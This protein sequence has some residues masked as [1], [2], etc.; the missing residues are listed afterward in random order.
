M[1]IKEGFKE[2]NEV[3]DFIKW[4]SENQHEEAIHRRSDVT[5]RLWTNIRIKENLLLK[6]SRLKWDNEG[7]SNSMYFHNVV[8]ERRRRNYIGSILS[9]RGLLKEVGDIKGE[10]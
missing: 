8:K 2:N 3:D 10:V 1:D 4:F 9:D 6:K 5:S 7:D